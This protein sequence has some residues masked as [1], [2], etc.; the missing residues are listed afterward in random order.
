MVTS[1]K[2]LARQQQQLLNWETWRQPE[3]YHPDLPLLKR[4][5]ERWVNDFH[6]R[7]D[8]EADPHKS[9]LERNLDLELKSLQ[10]MVNPELA[11]SYV[12]GDPETPLLVEQYR[13]FINSKRS[14]HAAKV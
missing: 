8:F 14:I 7:R 13:Q 5:I 6:F 9:L 2:G 3:N 1:I 10:I 11:R 12:S 4:G